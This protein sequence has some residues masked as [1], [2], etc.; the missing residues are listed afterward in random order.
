M[1]DGSKASKKYSSFMAGPVLPHSRLIQSMGD[2]DLATSTGEGVYIVQQPKATIRDAIQF[3]VEVCERVFQSQR[4][5]LPTLVVFDEGM[6]MFGPTGN[7]KHGDIVQR[8]FRAGRE[9]GLSPLFCTQRPK[10]INLQCL[11]E[12]N[13]LMLFHIDFAN[14]V[15]RLQEMGFPAELAPPEEDYHFI[16][17]RDRKVVSRDA[18]LNL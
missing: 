18:M 8:M 15:K 9:K 6:D 11:T 1:A 7:G 5:E 2:W 17:F 4:K 14:D 13:Y 10:T 3:A 16:Y 12:S